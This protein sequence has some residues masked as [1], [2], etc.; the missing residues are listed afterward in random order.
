M[1]ILI[2]LVCA[3]CLGGQPLDRRPHPNEVRNSPR[4]QE[5]LAQDQNAP[6]PSARPTSFAEQYFSDTARPIGPDSGACCVD[7]NC[8]AST[9]ENCTLAGGS[10]L[11]FG[12]ECVGW[13]ICYGACCQ[14]G[15]CL[16]S[17]Y[18]KS[19]CILYGGQFQGAGTK[20]STQ[21]IECPSCLGGCCLPGGGGCINLCETECT[22]QGG[23][24]MGVG[25]TCSQVCCTPPSLQGACCMLSGRCES[26]CPD[27]CNAISGSFL[28][29]GTSCDYSTYPYLQCEGACCSSYY[30]GC[31]VEG[32][33]VCIARGDQFLGT[34]VSCDQQVCPNTTGA[35]CAPEGYCWNIG[36][37]SCVSNGWNF[38][39]FGTACSPTTCGG[40][41]CALN[42]S[43]CVQARSLTDCEELYKG[44]Y[45]GDGSNCDTAI[46]CP[47]ATGACCLPDGKC[48]NSSTFQCI[49]E[50][51]EFAGEGVACTSVSCSSDPCESTE[52]CCHPHRSSGC[53]DADCCQLVCAADPFCCLAKFSP[54]NLWDAIC[55]DWANR[56]C[57][58]GS[59]DYCGEAQ[60]D[61]NHD[62]VVDLQDFSR[63]Q[64]TFTGP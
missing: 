34:G 55:V 22:S 10:F 61:L 47:N 20:C 28:G 50:L 7:Q 3:T 29:A 42:S 36:E 64:Q 13:D 32:P 26:M 49:L 14:G 62:G 16:G 9:A 60:S 23:T 58:D 37:G 45:Q 39:G 11:G 31:R 40:A 63:M 41:C 57:G 1:S 2:Q 6:G 5:I 48:A 52:S 38:H 44:H 59:G 8:V 43:N 25:L 4:I 56:L 24:F 12:S 15:T 21:D 54:S 46:D 35:C 19:N 30:G 27:I 33:G 53:S 18:T 51:G 17:L